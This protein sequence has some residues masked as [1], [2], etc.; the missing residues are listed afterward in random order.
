[1]KLPRSVLLVFGALSLAGGLALSVTASARPPGPGG[2]RLG[3][4][5]S[6]VEALD[7]DGESRTAI[8]AI[9]DEARV[10]QREV[11]SQ[12][13]EAR[14]DLRTLLEQ[15]EPDEAAVMEQAEVI[16]ALRTERR[17]QGLR[18]FLAV[19]A[20][21]TPEQRERLR[22]QMGGRGGPRFGGKR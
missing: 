2:D 12:L 7:L 3:R 4:L 20:L 6:R 9:L 5:E 14:E 21:L 8:Y 13:R 18:T 15:E 16:G 10:N 17:K 1:M 11:R 22:P 19:R